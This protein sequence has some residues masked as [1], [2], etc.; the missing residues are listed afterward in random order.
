MLSANGRRL[1][2]IRCYEV[3]HVPGLGSMGPVIDQDSAKSKGLGSLEMTYVDNGNVH[4]KVGRL[5]FVMGS[6]SVK[7]YDLLPEET[8]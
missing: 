3:T 7:T 4:C 8:K 2:S 5:E 6:A 1:K